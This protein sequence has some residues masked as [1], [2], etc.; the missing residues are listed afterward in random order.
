MNGLGI[1][2]IREKDNS[3]NELWAIFLPQSVG[4]RLI[5]EL[6]F[7]KEISTIFFTESVI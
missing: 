7:Q 1:K 3:T 2:L 6:F 4:V 5:K